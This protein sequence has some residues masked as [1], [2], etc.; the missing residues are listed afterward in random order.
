MNDVVIEI[1]HLSHHYGA[2]LAVAALSLQVRRGE[3][4]GIL[5][6]N[7]AGKTT[8]VRLLNGLLTPSSG[9]MTVLG[10]NPVTEGDQVRR[11]T[12]VL[13]ETPALYER[14]T[15]RQN[16]QF[17][18]TLAELSGDE[19][20][21]RSSKLLAFFGLQERADDRVESYSTGM[22]QR[23]AL[24]R[25]LLHEPL[26]LFLDEPTSGLDPEAAQ[27]VHELLGGIR[28]QD[29]H[30]VILCTHNLLEAERLCDR[31]AIIHQGRLL[32]VGSLP[33]LRRSLAPDLWV[34]VT[35]L[36]PQAGL[37]ERI[38][39]L[40]GV[41]AVECPHPATL[42]A[43]VEQQASIP[44]LV[45]QLVSVD[46]PVLSVQPRQ[47]SLEQIYFSLQEQA[48]KELQP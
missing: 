42:H 3:V 32:A 27:Q 9:R 18:G 21:K 33:E 7:G 39:R 35:F 6:P 29:G 40:P 4:L 22:K 30:T 45:A 26:I 23:L 19:I 13:T 47:A 31:L 28:R 36:T 12:G 15:A 16:L 8:T 44:G 37:A 24:A 20:K 38:A 5:G 11:F 2:R 10:R 25:T 48:D 43:R 46:A 14:L 34:D 41:L 17:F 1:D